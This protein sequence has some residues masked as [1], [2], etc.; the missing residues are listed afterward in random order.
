MEVDIRNVYRHD[1]AMLTV[2]PLLIHMYRDHV[3]NTVSHQSRVLHEL[4]GI[5]LGTGHR[6][7]IACCVQVGSGVEGHENTE[8]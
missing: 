6:K 7:A 8:G 2:A 3:Y 1:N 5:L 4:Q